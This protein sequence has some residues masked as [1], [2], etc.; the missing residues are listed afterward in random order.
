METYGKDI[1]GVCQCAG[2]TA[3]DLQEI[4][5][6]SEEDLHCNSLKDGLCGMQLLPF[7]GEL[8][9]DQGREGADINP[10]T[11]KIFLRHLKEIYQRTPFEN[12]NYI[13]QEG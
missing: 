6:V 5:Q 9:P 7:L 8:L 13:F 3:E 4:F 1:L 12:L 11:R 10:S 2:I